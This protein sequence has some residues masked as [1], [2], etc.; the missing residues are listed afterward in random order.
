[1]EAKDLKYMEAR[2][3]Y[4]LPVIMFEI[5]DNMARTD[6]GRYHTSKLFIDGKSIYSLLNI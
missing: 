2:D 4:G 1:M 3:V 5:T 6:K